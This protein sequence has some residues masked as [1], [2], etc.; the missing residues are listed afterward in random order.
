MKI[1]KFEQMKGGWFVGNFS[2]SAH[3]TEACEVSY[4]IHQKG[5]FWAPHIHRIATEINFLVKGKMLFQGQELNSG[6]IFVVEPS[7][8]GDPIFLED[9]ELVVVKTP[10]VLGDKYD[11]I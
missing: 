9:C 10:S 8:I 11:T 6:D 1:Y 4:K 3:V 7:E 2:P 5:E